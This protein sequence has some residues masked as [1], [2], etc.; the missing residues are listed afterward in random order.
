[1]KA[2]AVAVALNRVAKPYQQ[3]EKPLAWLA[4]LY[5]GLAEAL[6]T[7]TAVPAWLGRPGRKWPVWES[8]SHLAAGYDWPALSQAVDALAEV[9]GALPVRRQS[10]Y[11]RLLG[12]NGRAPLM[13]YE[14]QYLNGRFMG[15]ETFAVGA[16]Y[17]EAGLEIT[18]AELP[19]YAAVELEF[20]AFLVEQEIVQ[21]ENYRHWRKVRR[22]FIKEHAGRWLPQVGR[23]LA[24]VADPAWAAAGQLLVAALKPPRKR[25]TIQPKS[26]LP[27][28]INIEACN[29]CSF[30]VQVCPTRALRMQEDDQA[31]R[32]RLQPYLCIHCYKCEQACPENALDMLGSPI[33]E[34]TIVLRESPRAACPRCGKL[35]VSQAELA[36][37]AARLGS[38]P[39]WLDYCLDC[40]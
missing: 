35:T 40:R 11:K 22:L 1:M 37:V 18:G 7:D 39:A 21:P 25:R 15:P 24:A 32:L 27:R 29:L 38:H 12:G 2:P 13:L 19:D 16:L 20:L 6:A 31:T 36:A 34:A 30:C 17:R 8:A 5:A 9:S 28:I 33:E 14:S 26:G 4:A 3:P 10:A 23:Q